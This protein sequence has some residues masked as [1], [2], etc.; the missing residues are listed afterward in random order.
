MIDYLICFTL[1]LPNSSQHLN[2]T[3]FADLDILALLANNVQ[4]KLWYAHE[5]NHKRQ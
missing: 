3:Y 2:S 5:W 4:H 1:V